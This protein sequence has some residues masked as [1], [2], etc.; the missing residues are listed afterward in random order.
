[1]KK[2]WYICHYYRNVS[3]EEEATMMEEPSLQRL[4][5]A[6]DQKEGKK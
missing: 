5:E 2:G 3:I 6:L 1:M 4:M